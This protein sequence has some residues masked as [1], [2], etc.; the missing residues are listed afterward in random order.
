MNY[1]HAYHAG[2]HGDVLKHVVLTRVLTA[3]NKKDK[4]YRVIDAHAGAGLYALDGVEAG[5]TGEWQGGAGKL[6]ELFSPDIEALLAP[7]RGIIA[8]LNPAG[9][10]R[11][12]PGSPEIAAR[13]MRAGD[14]L[15]ANELHPEDSER[16]AGHFAADARVKVMRLDAETCVKAALPPPERRGL[17]LIDPPY[18]RKDEAAKALRMIAE[19][20]RRFATGVFML[21]YPVKGKGDDDA[22][23]EG[24]RSLGREGSLM[25]E[26]RVREAFKE[27]GLAGSGVIVVNAPWK[28]DEEL[29]LILPAL[30]KR[31]GLGS[32]GSGRTEWLTP[33]V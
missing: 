14:R 11:L 33:P 27:G 22:I 24:V 7:Y 1:R 26:L 6:G 28:L 8:A 31:L 29:A 4:P 16:L 2:N 25:A 10:L 15:I 13:M 30:G 19:G 12:Y 17:I 18:E 21:W 20:L 32:W 9:G 5:K 3:L 23:I